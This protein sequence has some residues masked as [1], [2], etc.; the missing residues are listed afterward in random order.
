MRTG[1]VLCLSSIRTSRR[2]C[3]SVANVAAPFLASKL[4]AAETTEGTGVG[5]LGKGFN[6]T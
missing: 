4:E 6:L 3:I 1:R 2:N 5:V